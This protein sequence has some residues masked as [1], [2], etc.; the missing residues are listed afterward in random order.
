MGPDE[1]HLSSSLLVQ[2]KMDMDDAR[3]L[4]DDVSS[5]LWGGDGRSDLSCGT[6]CVSSVKGDP[7]AS[8]HL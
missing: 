4:R 1:D 6:S 8:P 5:G 7:P 2:M 3:T